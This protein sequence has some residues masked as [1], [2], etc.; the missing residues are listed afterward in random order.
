MALSSS[1]LVQM[2]LQLLL[3]VEI[4]AAD[5]ERSESATERVRTESASL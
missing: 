2:T 4:L 5:A 1:S 3:A